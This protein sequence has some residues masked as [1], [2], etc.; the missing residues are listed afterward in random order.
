MERSLG[1]RSSLSRRLGGGMV[2]CLFRH[3]SRLVE[4]SSKLKS[5]H[6]VATGSRSMALAHDL[7]GV[8]TA[9]LQ[10]VHKKLSNVQ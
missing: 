7:P 2:E 5:C 10:M 1:S 6:L 4:G 8:T 9:D 3:R